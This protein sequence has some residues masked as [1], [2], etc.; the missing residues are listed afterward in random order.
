M[1]ALPDLNELARKKL[2]KE[3]DADRVVNFPIKSEELL[4]VI[5]NNRE[6]LKAHFD[7]KDA[8][9]YGSALFVLKEEME[10]LPDGKEALMASEIVSFDDKH[11]DNELVYG[12]T[13]SE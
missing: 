4:D 12:I 10:K 7:A 5:M 11:S 2:L 1:Y 8:K 3:G 6:E 13:K 9:L